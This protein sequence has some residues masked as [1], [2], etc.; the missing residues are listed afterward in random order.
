VT[1]DAPV[2]PGQVLRA[3]PPYRLSLTVEDGSGTCTYLTWHVREGAEGTVVR[4]D[5]AESDPTSSAES[6]LEVVWLP[7]LERLGQVLRD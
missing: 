1:Q 4:L 5:V 6:D 3:D 2:I 7:V